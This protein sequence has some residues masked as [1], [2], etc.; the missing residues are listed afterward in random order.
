M[1]GFFYSRLIPL[2][3]VGDDFYKF[4]LGPGM[5]YTSSLIKHF[6]YAGPLEELQNN[7][8]TVVCEKLDL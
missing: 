7:K 8:P 1:N 3:I 5:L 6:D 2:R 4:F